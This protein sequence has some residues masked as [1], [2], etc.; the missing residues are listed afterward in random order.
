MYIRD[1]SLALIGSQVL[2][3]A[4][5]IGGNIFV[6]NS[7]LS[8]RDSIF[9]LNTAVKGGG[10]A[11]SIHNIHKL[12]INKLDTE[13]YD[14]LVSI[15]NCSF[16]NNEADT[17]GAI[18]IPIIDDTIITASVV[19]ENITQRRRLLATAVSDTPPVMDSVSIDTINSG[20]CDG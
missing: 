16:T 8:L 17:A 20:S 19:A 4:S 14:D 2:D 1:G 11:V 9:D 5:P 3:N 15:D 12:I 10:S 6:D 18:Y 13:R 7:I